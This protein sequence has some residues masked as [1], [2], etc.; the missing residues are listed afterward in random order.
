M[1]VLQVNALFK[2]AAPAPAKAAVFVT[3]EAL[4][5]QV[6]DMWKHAR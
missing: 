5:P 2:K 4:A 6:C 3:R 1:A